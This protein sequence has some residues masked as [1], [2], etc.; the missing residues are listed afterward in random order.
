MLGYEK[1]LL[2]VIGNQ[3]LVVLFTPCSVIIKQICSEIE[4]ASNNFLIL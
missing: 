4:V 3:W 2:P 1:N